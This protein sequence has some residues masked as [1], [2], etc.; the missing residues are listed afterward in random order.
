MTSSN[1]SSTR[2]CPV[3]DAPNNS[4][5]LFCSECGASLDTPASSDTSSYLAADADE[6]QKTAAFVPATSSSSAKPGS[7]PAHA[8]PGSSPDPIPASWEST[9]PATPS[10]DR[11]WSAPDDGVLPLAPVRRPS[12]NRGFVLGLIARLLVLAIFLLWT[13]ASILSQDTRNSI[14]DLFGFFN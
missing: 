1:T 13:W 3:C 9:R 2:T 7:T 4:V 8:T 12:N 6:A 10:A 11:V 14:Q 5:S